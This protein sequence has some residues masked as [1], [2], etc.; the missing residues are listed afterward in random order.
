MSRI[1]DVSVPENS[2]L[3]YVLK[4]FGILAVRCGSVVVRERDKDTKGLGA[5]L[6]CNFLFFFFF[7]NRITLNNNSKNFPSVLKMPATVC[8]RD[9]CAGHRRVLSCSRRRHLWPKLTVLKLASFN[10]ECAYPVKTARWKFL[11]PQLL[12]R[13]PV[14]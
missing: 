3:V 13:K 9:D 4:F 2:L 10:V 6:R 12:S 8:K 14:L 7:F 11:C 5:T 1:I